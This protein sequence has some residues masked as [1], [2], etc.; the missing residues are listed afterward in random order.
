[1][2]RANEKLAEIAVDSIDGFEQYRQTMI[3][4]MKN[5]E[6]IGEAMADGVL[7]DEAIEKAVNNFMATTTQFSEWYE[8]WKGE[9]SNENTNNI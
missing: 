7:S 8:Q 9:I 4:E 1:M 3:S 2:N 5:D 6:T